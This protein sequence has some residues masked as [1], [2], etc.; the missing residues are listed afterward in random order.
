M[1]DQDKPLVTVRQSPCGS[2]PYRRDVPSGLWAASE[3]NKLPGYDGQTWEQAQ[4]GATGLFFCHRTPEFLCAGWVSCHDMDNNLAMRL[5]ARRQCVDPAVYDYESPV[6]LFATGAQ[7]AAHGLRD[8][9]D[10]GEAAR[11]N[12]QQLS[13]I[14][15]RRKK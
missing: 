2:C 11:D 14:I 1:A 4:A 9:D 13:H 7:A 12:V 8:I 6:P 15:A 3:Y 10:P 5:H